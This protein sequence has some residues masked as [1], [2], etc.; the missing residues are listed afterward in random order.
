MVYDGAVPRHA[1]Q[2]KLPMPPPL[3]E[4]FAEIADQRG[5]TRSTLLFGFALRGAE[6]A[7]AGHQQWLPPIR[8][9]KAGPSPASVWW[10]QAPGETAAWTAEIRLRHSSLRGVVHAWIAAY[11]RAEGDLLRL[12][13]CWELYPPDQG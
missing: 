12:A 4:R 1:R 6:A 9:W 2:V 10:S 11:N 8:S 3:T 13:E 5:H 7:R